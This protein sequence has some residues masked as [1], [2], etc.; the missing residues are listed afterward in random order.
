MSGLFSRPRVPEPQPITYTPQV[1]SVTKTAE[2]EAAEAEKEVAKSKEEVKEEE[3]KKIRKGRTGK[4]TILTGPQG[5]L[6][7]AKVEYKTLLGV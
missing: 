3:K 7:P 1:T 4:G 5:I 2:K 6:T